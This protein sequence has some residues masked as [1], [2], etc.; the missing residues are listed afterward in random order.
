MGALCTIEV[1]LVASVL[2]ARAGTGPAP[3]GPRQGGVFIGDTKDLEGDC[4]TKGMKLGLFQSDPLPVGNP[5]QTANDDL[6]TASE[7]GSDLDLT[8]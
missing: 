1:D 4:H 2:P 3:T 8:P 6:F 5:L 7:S